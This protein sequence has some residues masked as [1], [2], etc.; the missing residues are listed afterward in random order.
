M[1]SGG[2][3]DDGDDGMRRVDGRARAG[4]LEAVNCGAGRCGA[5]RCGAVRLCTSIARWTV[6]NV[7]A[8]RCGAVGRDRARWRARTRSAKNGR[9]ALAQRRVQSDAHGRS[10][11]MCNI[12]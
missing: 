6:D 12:R 11:P 3:G 5:V 9:R 8:V 2:V 7:R 4:V 1:G 10:T